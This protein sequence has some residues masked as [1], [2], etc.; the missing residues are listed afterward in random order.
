MQT[1][2]LYLEVPPFHPNKCKTHALSVTN[3][4]WFTGLFMI[5]NLRT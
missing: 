4:L 3:N 5:N 1:S 2:Q